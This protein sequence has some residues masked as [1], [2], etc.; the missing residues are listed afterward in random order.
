MS[1]AAPRLRLAAVLALLLLAH[2]W[3]RPALF[4]G[5]FAPDFVF[6]A[7]LFFA[8]RSRPGAAA[9]AGLVVGLLTDAVAPT[10]FGAAAFALTIVGYAAGWLKALV[11]ADNLLVTAVF[12]FAASWLRDLLELAASNAL[13]GAAVGTQLLVFSPVAAL[14]TAAAAVVALF[15]FRP[16]L[17]SAPTL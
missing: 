17:R 3:L 11:F 6:V 1:V 15:L 16:W 12:V 8:I 10:T 9:L 7:L 13:R 14:S 2:L 4:P 5:R